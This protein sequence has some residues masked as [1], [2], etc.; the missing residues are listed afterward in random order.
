MASPLVRLLEEIGVSLR[1]LNDDLI[2][3]QLA[4][5]GPIGFEVTFPPVLEASRQWVIAQGLREWFLSSTRAVTTVLILTASLP[6]RSL[7]TRRRSFS[8][9][10]V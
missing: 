8:D 6:F 5:E 2:S 1:A 10:C 7:S 9:R 4:R 3:R